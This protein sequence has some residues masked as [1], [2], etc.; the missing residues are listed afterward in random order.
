MSRWT[1]QLDP[2]HLFL[3]EAKGFPSGR[4][5]DPFFL[6]W[7]NAESNFHHLCL[8][9]VRRHTHG[10]GNTLPPKKYWKKWK[11]IVEPPNISCNVSRLSAYLIKKAFCSTSEV[12]NRLRPCRLP[13]ADQRE[14]VSR[15]WGFACLRAPVAGVP[16]PTTGP[17]TRVVVVVV[18]D[19]CST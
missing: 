6:P 8:W 19:P 14:P 13:P 9:G 1:Q 17:Q 16:R 7:G 2:E 3:K 11:E 18:G 15:G 4:C 10:E 5:L 12:P